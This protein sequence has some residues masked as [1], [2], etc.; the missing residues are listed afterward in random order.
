MK[1]WK[2]GYCLKRKKKKMYLKF[3]RLFSSQKHIINNNSDQDAQWLLLVEEKYADSSPAVLCTII[4]FF[5]KQRTLFKRICIFFRPGSQ[6]TGKIDSFLP[7]SSSLLKKNIQNL[8]YDLL[9]DHIAIS[10]ESQNYLWIILFWQQ[11]PQRN[12][13]NCRTLGQYGKLKD[14]TTLYIQICF[15]SENYTVNL[16]NSIV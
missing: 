6:A 12:V 3:C 1:I 11:Q 15:V 7:Y 4:E 16:I 2:I 10:F 13:I 14:W 5:W 9:L 8:K